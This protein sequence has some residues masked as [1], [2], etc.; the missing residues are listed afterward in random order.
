MHPAQQ[1]TLDRIKAAG[2]QASSFKAVSLEW[3]A[4]KDWE[5]V[6]KAR[7]RSVLERTAY[8]AIGRLPVNQIKPAHILDLLKKARADN[9]PSV[10]D[11]LKHTLSGIFDLAISTLR[12]ETNPVL[13]VMK[14]VPANK[15]Q[16]KRPLPPAEIGEFLRELEDYSG[17]FQTVSALKLMWL[18]LCRPGEAVEAEWGEFDLEAR[19]W[20]IREGRMKKRKAHAIPLS[21]Q[22]VAIV[23]A[24]QHITG[25]RTHLFPHRDH[26]GDPAGGHQRHGLGR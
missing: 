25:H 6:T 1:H 19:I 24:M 22:A 18:T 3:L 17:H 15:T 4:L 21:G 20:T 9:G 2:E 11:E 12:A 7:R 5:E 16:H 13:P 23:K 10:A 8:P 26:H 14:A